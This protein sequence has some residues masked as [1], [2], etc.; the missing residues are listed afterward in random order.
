MDSQNQTLSGDLSDETSALAGDASLAAFR[1]WALQ[2]G[3]I[4][5]LGGDASWHVR[6]GALGLDDSDSRPDEIR[7]QAE[8]RR[9]LE[10]D[11]GDEIRV[12]TLTLIGAGALFALTVN[13]FVP[14]GVTLSDFAFLRLAAAILLTMAGIVIFLPRLEPRGFAI[15]EQV[16]MAI[17][18]VIVAA[19]CASTGGA[20]SPFSVWWLFP[21]FYAAYFLPPRVAYTHASV[22]SIA[23]LSPLI[24]DAGAR[25]A[26]SVFTLLLLTGVI[27]VLLSTL[28]L[29]R[30]HARDA[31]RAVRFL[32]LADPLTG[33]ANLRAFERMLDRAVRGTSREFAL[34]LADL[35]GLKGANASFGYE[36]GDDMLRRLAAVMLHVS[37]ERDQVARLRGDEF[38]V[39][40]ADAGEQEAEAWCRRLEASLEQHNSW[41]RNRL[42]Q[43]S[44]S[45]GVAVFPRDGVRPKQLF[46]TADRRM[47]DQKSR[48]IRPPH[49]VEVSVAA[50]AA[51]LLEPDAGADERPRRQTTRPLLKFDIRW[52]AASIIFTT[53]ALVPASDA[54]TRPAL[55]GLA[56]FCLVFAFAGLFVRG[57]R[58]V[59]RFTKISDVATLAVLVPGMWL[60]GGWESPLQIASFFPIVYYAQF[61]RG[62]EAATRIAAVIVLY[63]V[64]FWGAE[65]VGASD[66]PPSDAAETQFAMIVAA[67]LV[68][69]V[70]LQYNR[71]VTDAAIRRIRDSATHDPLTSVLNLRTFRRDLAAALEAAAHVPAD[72]PGAAPEGVAGHDSL[73]ALLIADI[74]DFRAV[75]NLGG[76]LAGDAV[77]RETADQLRL[78]YGESGS[79]YRIDSDEFAVL[80]NV[81]RPDQL[82]QRV[83]AARALL[84]PVAPT[85]SGLSAP[86]TASVGG[87]VWRSGMDAASLVEAARSE[88]VSQRG[89]QS[90]HRP[91]SG[92]AVL[93]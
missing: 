80:A 35:R 55:F 93:L 16:I 22:V 50:S 46:E 34:V 88:L 49:E 24:Y 6:S 4:S 65:A 29:G 27:W 64:G 60:T 61:A 21:I 83:V 5:M 75:N 70:L 36:V 86:V 52:L 56:V 1:S 77:L 12:K 8:L 85:V 89:G 20:E 28:L 74:D 92:G 3:S 91:D 7:G 87:A 11:P 13:Q 62:R 78:L 72:A 59:E 84:D 45:L 38:V 32:A 43:I 48:S 9:E 81:E 25:D 15:A 90:S 40:L 30:E 66:S 39:M 76:H 73:P 68:I 67:Q 42:P 14:F 47:F 10:P 19:L 71:R 54:G 51:Q 23:A 2:T 53:W 41:I 31:E 58:A 57:R 69:A 33:V 17:A 26:N 63:A 79:V 37:G 82:A 44:A 18:W